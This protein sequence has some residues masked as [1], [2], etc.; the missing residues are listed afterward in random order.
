MIREE[1]E[2]RQ[3]QDTL[4]YRYDG[5]CERGNTTGARILSQRIRALDWVL[6]EDDRTLDLS[7]DQMNLLADLI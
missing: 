4:R 1:E 3:M 7:D 5:A 6:G 2:I